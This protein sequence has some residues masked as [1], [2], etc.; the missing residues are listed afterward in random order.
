MRLESILIVIVLA[1]GCAELS[2]VHGASERCSAHAENG[3]HQIAVPPEAEMLMQLPSADLTIPIRSFLARRSSELSAWFRNSNGS[4]YA[5]A[6]TPRQN[7]CS[8]GSSRTIEFKRT[9][10]SWVAGRPLEEECALID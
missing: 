10:S 2:H 4:L 3:W 8:G 1:E 7:A 5:C 9:G 6:Y